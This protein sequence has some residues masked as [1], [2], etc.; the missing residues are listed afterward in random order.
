MGDNL[1]DLPMVKIAGL[2]VAVANATE[3]LK[4][5]ADF[6]SV[7]NNDGAVAQIIEKFG[8]I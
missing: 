4:Q 7:S 8:F 3:K 1:N 2:G 6:I 5:A